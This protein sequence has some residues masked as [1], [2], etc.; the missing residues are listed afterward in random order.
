MRSMHLRLQ[1]LH[2]TI[3]DVEEIAGA[4]GGVKHFEF[5]HPLQKLAELRQRFRPFNLLAPRLD[6]RRPDNHR[7][8]SAAEKHLR[9]QPTLDLR[10]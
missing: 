9:G 6:D 2:F 4:A 7:R 1:S 3:G 8:R 10:V 5:V